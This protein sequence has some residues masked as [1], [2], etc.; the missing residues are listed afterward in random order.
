MAMRISGG[1][2][3]R[4]R[5]EL[6]EEDLRQVGQYLLP[7]NRN[8]VSADLSVWIRMDGVEEFLFNDPVSYPLGLLSN[9][10]ELFAGLHGRGVATANQTPVSLTISEVVVEGLCKEFGS[11]YFRDAPSDESLLSCGWCFLGFDTV[12]LN[13]L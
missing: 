3:M 6:Q 10:D 11:D 1:F 8:R 4:V 9:L 2:D 7:E 13:G 12:E 5:V